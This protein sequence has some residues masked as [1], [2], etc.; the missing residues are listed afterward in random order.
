VRN[1][2]RL[3]DMQPF[4]LYGVGLVSLIVTKSGKRLGD[5]AA[6]TLVVKEDLVHPS[7]CHST[8]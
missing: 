4:V 5:M 2:V 1:V 8:N 6:G 3:V 7:R